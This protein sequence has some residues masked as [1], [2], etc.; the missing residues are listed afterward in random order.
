LEKTHRVFPTL[1]Q[2]ALQWGVCNTA[3]ITNA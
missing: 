1:I 2:D 3:R